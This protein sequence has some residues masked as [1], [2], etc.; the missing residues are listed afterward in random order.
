MAREIQSYNRPAAVVS[1]D[2]YVSPDGRFVNV[3]STMAVLFSDDFGGT[4]LD[5]LR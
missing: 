2:P 5:P 4:V 3:Q 1:G